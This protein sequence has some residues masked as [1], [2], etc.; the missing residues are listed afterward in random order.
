MKTITKFEI[1]L[2][3]EKLA[4]V[5]WINFRLSK[6]ELLLK[7]GNIPIAEDGT[8]LFAALRDGIILK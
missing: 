5:D 4:F 2:H 3:Q 8:A 7:H 6:D 1:Y